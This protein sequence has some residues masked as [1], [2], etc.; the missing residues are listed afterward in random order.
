LTES[1]KHEQKIEAQKKYLHAI[2]TINQLLIKTNDWQKPL[3]AC[4]KIVGETINVDRVY[5][6]QNNPQQ[7]TTSQQVQWTRDGIEPLIDSFNLQNIPYSQVSLFMGPLKKQRHFEAIVEELPPSPIK[8]ILKAQKIKSLLV[9]PIWGNEGF[10]GFIVLGDCRNKRTF[11]EDEFRLL[12]TLTSNI[13]H[14]IKRD[15]T[16]QK[17]S[18]SK[19][20]FKSLIENGKDLIAITDEKGNYKYAAPTYKRVLGMAPEDFLGK[21]TFDFIHEDD[22]PRLKQ[23]LNKVLKSKYVLMEPYRF[24][25]ADGKW[26]WVRTEITNHL[27]T[28]LIKGLVANTQEVTA[29]VE[30]RIADE[31]IAALT[32]VIGQTGSLASCLNEA[33]NRLV[34]LF[35]INACEIWLVSP[36]ATQLDLIAKACQDNDFGKFYQNSSD[37]TSLEKGSGLPGHIWKELKTTSWKDIS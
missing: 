17:L 14:I 36:D 24:A 25:H 10:F 23:Y 3:N 4:F 16:Y 11:N 34:K 37:V 32:L 15:E 31:L 18:H 1:Y 20:R 8:E 22:R 2:G 5:F 21:N 19:S 26:R 35:K 27:N 29:E 6:F 28:P 12:H 33:L 30:K 9:L 7:Q 13:G